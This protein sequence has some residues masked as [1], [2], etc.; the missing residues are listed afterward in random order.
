MPQSKAVKLTR[1]KR[2]IVRFMKNITCNEAIYVLARIQHFVCCGQG[3]VADEAAKH[4]QRA[5][6]IS[7]HEQQEIVKNI[8]RHPGDR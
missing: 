1:I 2:I 4:L 3:R 6:R 5:H 8:V 7:S